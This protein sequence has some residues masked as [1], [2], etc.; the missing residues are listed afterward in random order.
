MITNNKVQFAKKS[1]LVSVSKKN[2]AICP[3]QIDE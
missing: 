3:H 2:D 1:K